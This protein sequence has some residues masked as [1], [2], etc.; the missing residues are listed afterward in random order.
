MGRTRKEESR[1]GGG[2]KLRYGSEK[3]WENGRL[4]EGGV[5]GR[6]WGERGRRRAKG[7]EQRG[8]M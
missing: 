8:L 3:D 1:E 7:V 2:G 6:V 5:E 4:L